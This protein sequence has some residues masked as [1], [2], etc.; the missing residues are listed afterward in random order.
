MARNAPP[1]A[2][3]EALCARLEAAGE[4]DGVL[5]YD[6]FCAT[7]RYGLLHKLP[8][9]LGIAFLM[10]RCLRVGHLSITSE[11][12]FLESVFGHLTHNKKTL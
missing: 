12:V 9:P 5:Q 6:Y 1:T 10:S 4:L 7:T 11:L 3:A 8:L 2:E